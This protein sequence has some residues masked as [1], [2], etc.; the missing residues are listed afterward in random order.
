MRS[1]SIYCQ[2]V[3]NRLD[4]QLH[5][6][7]EKL[8]ESLLAAPD[9]Y[10]CSCEQPGNCRIVLVTVINDDGTT[11]LEPSFVNC[12]CTHVWYGHHQRQLQLI[13]AHLRDVQ[14]QM[15]QLNA[16]EGKLE[17]LLLRHRE[18]GK[19][20]IRYEQYW[21]RQDYARTDQVRQ[22]R[23]DAVG[24]RERM[25]RGKIVK[26][27]RALTADSKETTQDYHTEVLVPVDAEDLGLDDEIYEFRL[28]ASDDLA[29]GGQHIPKIK[30]ASSTQVKGEPQTVLKTTIDDI[31]Q[32]QYLTLEQ[33]LERFEDFK[34]RAAALMAQWD[35][36]DD[37]RG[38]K[39]DAIYP[40]VNRANCVCTA[41][42][43][44]YHR[45]INVGNPQA[46]VELDAE[47]FRSDV[48]VK[49][50]Q[51][52]T[53]ARGF[54]IGELLRSLDDHMKSQMSDLVVALRGEGR[55]KALVTYLARYD[56]V[57]LRVELGG[58]ASEART[59]ELLQKTDG[60]L[61]RWANEDTSRGFAVCGE[62]FGKS[63]L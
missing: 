32:G 51:A 3:R 21:L 42:Q 6:Y 39:L 41:E 27:E 37:A 29:S 52:M 5:Y 14:V 46:Y 34:T 13:N 16:L 58:Y 62:C 23:N 49:E 45:C 9:L 33:V 10:S 28:C 26:V 60:M 8:I 63:R 57:D 31:R 17:L 20:E 30:D 12:H 7:V 44:L 18:F 19:A 35:D 40:Q 56:H 48:Q 59:G 22:L 43:K 36:E 24:R 38:R 25:N 2:A 61:E 53:A 54:E 11:Y 50:Q 47:I 15:A 4:T 1:L 55:R